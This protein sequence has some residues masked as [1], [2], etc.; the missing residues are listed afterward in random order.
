MSAT[1]YEKEI[2]NKASH[3]D[4]IDNADVREFLSESSYVREPSTAEIESLCTL[5]QAVPEVQD[6]TLP[7]HIFA[8]DG[9]QYE[10]RIDDRLPSTKVGYI[11]ISTIH[12]SMDEFGA[13][14]VEEGNFVDPFRVAKLR[15]NKDSLL[16]VL[17]GSNV[18]WKGYE[19]VRDSFRARMDQELLKQETRFDKDDYKTSLRST[20]FYLAAMRPDKM[21][22]GDASRIRLHKCPSCDHPD[23]ELED[24]LDAQHC[25]NCG[26]EVY[27]TDAL[28]IWEE[29][30]DFQSNVVPMT[31]FML[32]IEHML[33]VHY[34]RHLLKANFTLAQLSSIAFFLDGPLAIFGTCAWLHRPLMQFYTDVNS[35]L[36]DEGLSDVTIIGLQKTGQLADY[37]GII[38]QYISNNMM[39]SVDDDYRYK[40]VIASREPS[41]T[42]FGDETYYG[43]DFLYKT[44]S[45]KRFVVG[46]P[47]PFSSKRDLREGNFHD[48]KTELCNYPYLARAMELIRNFETDLYTNA[49]IPVALAHRYTAI[50]A[51]PGGRVLDILSQNVFPMKK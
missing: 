14:R 21:G 36:R 50:S 20:L 46:L 5:F 7:T 44:P 26:K 23:L 43:Q 41:K 24:I 9:S 2:A 29:V 49:V 40:Y 27:P 22:T 4:I 13:L 18:K 51:M 30:S 12:I 3:S 47:Y 19:S 6:G 15:R 37:F 42:G 17:P 38:D 1:P 48:I 33:P 16:F 31:R 25:P 34:L 11:K 39:L 35:R 8:I 10:S 28:R 45:G 32:T